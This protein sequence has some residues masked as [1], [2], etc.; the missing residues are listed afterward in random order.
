LLNIRGVKRMDKVVYMQFNTLK[1]CVRQQ[2]KVIYEAE[3]MFDKIMESPPSNDRGKELSACINAITMAR[4]SL[5]H[6][7]MKE[8]MEK[9]P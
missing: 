6:F 3:Q 2:C 5:L 9:I 4:Q 8:P 1:K 7:G